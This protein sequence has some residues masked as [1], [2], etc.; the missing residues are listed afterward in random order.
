MIIFVTSSIVVIVRII[1]M[2]VL[3]L[4][5]DKRLH[6]LM[7][8]VSYGVMRNDCRHRQQYQYF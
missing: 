3:M 8:M 7:M 6:I 5:L 4:M 2:M 1:G